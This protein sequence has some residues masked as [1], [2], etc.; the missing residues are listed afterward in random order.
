MIAIAL[1]V[2]LP[3]LKKFWPYIAGAVVILGVLGYVYHRGGQ[4]ER[5]RTAKATLEEN[6]RQRRN[7]ETIEEHNRQL[8]DPAALERLRPPR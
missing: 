7:R 5:D 6:E 8:D 3:F 4:D 1:E 2:L